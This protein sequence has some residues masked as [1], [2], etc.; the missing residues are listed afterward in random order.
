MQGAAANRLREV[1]ERIGAV[2]ASHVQSLGQSIG[3]KDLQDRLLVVCEV[4]PEIRRK[5][6]LG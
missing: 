1:R 6:S 5:D 3:F 2:G 4:L